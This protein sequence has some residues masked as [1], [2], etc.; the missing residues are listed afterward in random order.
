MKKELIQSR[1]GTNLK[2][3]N[4][5]SDWTDQSGTFV[6]QMGQTAVRSDFLEQIFLPKE[7]RTRNRTPNHSS[8]LGSTLQL[9]GIGVFAKADV[10]NFAPA[11]RGTP[12]CSMIIAQPILLWSHDLFCW[13]HCK[14]RCSCASVIVWPLSK[15]V[16]SEKASFPSGTKNWLSLKLKKFILSFKTSM[17]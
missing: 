11:Q 15:R 2:S 1:Y 6:Q 5:T 3:C 10:W 14:I 13:R 8:F 16:S 4:E 9:E 17:L 12:S 7:L